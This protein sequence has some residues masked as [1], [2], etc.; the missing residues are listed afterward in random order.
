M[1]ARPCHLF[2]G[3]RGG[4]GLGSAAVVCCCGLWGRHGGITRLTVGAI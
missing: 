1:L 4:I 2:G 3:G